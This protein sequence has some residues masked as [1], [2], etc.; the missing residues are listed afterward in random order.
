MTGMILADRYEVGEVIGTGG[1]SDVYAATDTL[2][3]RP[4]AVKMMRTELARDA[5]FRE[6][7]RREA[8]NS[9]RLNHPNIVQ[10]YDTAEVELSGIKVPYLVM[11][12]V[13]GETLRDILRDRGPYSVEE[14][15]RTLV[16]VCNALAASHTAGIIH[17]DIKPG[18][19]MITNTGDVKV[20]DFG[21]ARALDDASAMTQTAAVIGTAQYLSPEQA[22]GKSADIRSDVYA[23][24]CVLYEMVTGRPPFEGES[25]FA[26]AYQHVKDDPVAPSQFVCDAQ[27]TTATNIDAVTL[28]AM[29]KH[30]EDRYQTA[31]EMAEDLE[32]VARGAVSQAARQHTQSAPV[33]SPPPEPA[34]QTTEFAP[35]SAPAPTPAP[36]PGAPAAAAAP[37]E[38]PRRNKGLAIALGSIIALAAVGGGGWFLYDQFSGDTNKSAVQ[39]QMVTVPDVTNFTQEDATK[40]LMDLGLKPVVTPESNPKIPEGHVIST[41]PGKGS[42]L[43]AGTD[44]RLK[45]ST[46]KEVTEVPDLASQTPEQASKLLADAGL[47]LDPNVRQ[48]PSDSVPAGAIIEHSPAAGSRVSKGTK[49]SI[50]I[51]TGV[52]QVRI[53]ALT[54]MKWDQAQGNLTSAGFRPQV[55]Q[56]DNAAPAGT[57]LSVDGEGAL[58]DKGSTVLVKVSKGNMF[59]MPDLNRLS[60]EDALAKLHQSGYTGQPRFQSVPTAVILDRDLIAGQSPAPGTQLR[61]DAP[62]SLS[63]FDFLGLDEVKPPL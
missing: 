14:A 53:P 42:Q 47:E 40:R 21:I 57:V 32:R 28:T 56:V 18:N 55:Q 49:V 48:K 60:K 2:L 61:K 37:S 9:G 45:V 22:R 38:K 34:P 29:A 11:E 39:Q 59:A 6:R 26:V 50:T 25:P 19:I 15:A 24:G 41:E 10:V 7:F 23:L 3:G 51:S 1:M 27:P 35:S 16:P 44:I 20:M 31:Q 12:R 17:R 54:G 43:P 5:N 62:I 63:V 8:K 30:P 13:H 33:A 4:V 58:V 52:E 36:A 46:G